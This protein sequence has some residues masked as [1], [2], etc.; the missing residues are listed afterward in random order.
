MT[1]SP[2]LTSII[3]FWPSIVSG[4]IKSNPV[5]VLAS[6]IELT[7]LYGLA[8]WLSCV[9]IIFV[10]STLAV[11]SFLLLQPASD[12]TAIEAVRTVSVFF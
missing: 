4:T 5:I 7:S 3:S 6:A 2:Y 8:I 12:K 10:S 9:S 11:S 1:S